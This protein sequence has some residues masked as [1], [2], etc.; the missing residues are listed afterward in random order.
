MM[1]FWK[2][3]NWHIS[4]FAFKLFICFVGPQ[5]AYWRS[6][7]LSQHFQQTEEVDEMAKAKMERDQQDN[8]MK[9]FAVSNTFSSADINHD[10]LTL[11]DGWENSTANL[12]LWWLDFK[13]KNR[14][15][16]LT[17]KRL[18]GGG[19]GW[20]NPPPSTFSATIPPH[21][22]FWPRRSLTFYFQVSRI[23]WHHFRENRAYRYDAARPFI[24]ARQT[25]NGS[26]TWFCVQS[27]CKWSFLTLF[28]KIWLFSLSLAEINS[29]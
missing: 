15:L 5:E 28:I 2:R 10:L 6:N 25:E 18:G 7:L 21:E 12:E 14:M 24:H 1:D 26:K 11:V 20:I 19:G 9:M 22:I 8:L 29:F 27:Q 23:L 3:W 17:L 13:K 16:P 4:V